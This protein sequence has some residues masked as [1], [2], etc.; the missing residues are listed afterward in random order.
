[1]RTPVFN[2]APGKT[3]NYHGCVRIASNQCRKMDDICDTC[4]FCDSCPSAHFHPAG[5]NSCADYRSMFKN[6]ERK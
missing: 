2:I 3:I 1:M 6:K 5:N 4:A